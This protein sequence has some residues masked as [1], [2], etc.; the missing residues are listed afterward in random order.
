[1]VQCWG[2][3]MILYQSDKRDLYN[4]PGIVLWELLEFIIR[5]L[6]IEYLLFKHNLSNYH[7]ED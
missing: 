3:D 2:H 4:R 7:Y 1:M 6:D 5:T